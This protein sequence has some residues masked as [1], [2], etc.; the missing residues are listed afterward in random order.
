MLFF[1]FKTIFIEKM[2]V[3]FKTAGGKVFL[4]VDYGTTVKEL[5]KKFF[6][7]I[8]RPDLMGCKDIFFIFNAKKIEYENQTPIEKFFNPNPN[9]VIIVNNLL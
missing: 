2:N 7:R 3:I 5:L 6:D 1:Y 4:V 9:P 8:G